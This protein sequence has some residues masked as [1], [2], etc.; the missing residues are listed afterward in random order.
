MIRIFTDDFRKYNNIIS[1]AYVK[2]DPKTESIYLDFVNSYAYFNYMDSIARFQFKFEFEEGKYPTIDSNIFI[3]IPAFLTLCNAYDYWDLDPVNNELSHD[4][5]VFSIGVTKNTYDD[6]FQSSE[7]SEEKNPDKFILSQD[8]V[9]LDMRAALGYM[10]ED[11]NFDDSKFYHLHLKGTSIVTSDGSIIFEAKG[12]NEF[13]DIAISGGGLKL[14]ILGLSSIVDDEAITLYD[15]KT[16][17]LI[18]TFGENQ[19]EIL[20]PKLLE[21]T[22]PNLDDP[23][24]ISKYHHKTS[25]VVKKDDI[26]DI[27]K[28]YE[29]LVREEINE[30]LYLIVNNKEE[31][32]I[33]TKDT[34]TG[35]RFVSLI[36]C[37]PA[38][39]GLELCFSRNLLLQAINSIDDSNIELEIDISQ[40][41]FNVIGAENKNR[42]V[43]I[44]RLSN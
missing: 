13:S 37:D 44:I 5:V 20:T 9:I 8:Q 23:D 15:Y 7:I 14:L 1:Q 21:F 33:E 18:L 30:R 6:L 39:L 32:T 22:S 34:N 43:A 25:L 40:P 28:F 35:N 11:G 3:S 26:T 10:G 36:S 29:N 42:H 19:L 31:I 4:R 38:L 27:L 41:A 2:G 12:E 16:N 24:F 17:W